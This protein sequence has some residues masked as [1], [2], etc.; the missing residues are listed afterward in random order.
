MR[1]FLVISILLL[2]NAGWGEVVFMGVGKDGEVS[3]SD[4]AHSGYQPVRL[5][6]PPRDEQAAALTRSRI[7][8]IEEI[9]DEMAERRE[10]RSEARALRT[11][12]IE[13]VPEYAE[14]ENERYYGYPD[15]RHYPRGPRPPAVAPP[16]TRPPR[17]TFEPAFYPRSLNNR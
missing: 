11:P 9:A 2:S 10:A 14:P 4:E 5:E 15:A 6:V 16:P 17:E 8:E 7:A 13:Y 12:A 3:F 1:L